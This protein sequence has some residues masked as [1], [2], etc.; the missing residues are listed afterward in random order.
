MLR[1]MTAEASIS[2]EKP[3]RQNWRSNF[4]FSLDPPGFFQSNPI[5][6]DLHFVQERR[7]LRSDMALQT[8]RELGMRGGDA[9]TVPKVEHLF[10]TDLTILR[11][12]IVKFVGH[13]RWSRVERPVSRALSS[14]HSAA[15]RREKSSHSHQNR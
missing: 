15:Y 4:V 13:H 2:Q 5:A 12:E 1:V 14:A 7:R 6:L 9:Y 8:I 3:V 10:M 11:P